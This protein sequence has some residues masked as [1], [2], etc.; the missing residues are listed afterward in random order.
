[1]PGIQLGSLVI[2][3]VSDDNKRR[4]GHA[5]MFLP[6]L[7][8]AM[9]IFAALNYQ[10]SHMTMAVFLFS[11]AITLSL[12]MLGLRY[13]ENVW[14]LFRVNV[15]LLCLMGVY[16]AWAGNKEG[17][18]VLAI[19]IYPVVLFYFFEKLEACFWVSAVLVPSIILLL[20]PEPF[21]A[22]DY[23]EV[24][25]TRIAASVL[26]V[27]I[28]SYLAESLRQQAYHELS[29]EKEKLERALQEIDTLKGI[30]PIC[31]YCKQIRDDDGM[32]NKIEKYFTEHS[33]A[34]FSHSICPTCTD[35]HFPGL[36][37]INPEAQ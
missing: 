11:L 24:Y 14:P 7:V 13:L 2:A 28:F 9:L 23:G 29:Q 22:Y 1:M 17:A 18:S 20:F 35:E 12:S 4:R 16:F 36:D 26:M 32:W 19:Y 3:N 10:S 37:E 31:S 27:T 25:G 5:V 21:G 30:I 15:A 33:N 34:D 8:L 6:G